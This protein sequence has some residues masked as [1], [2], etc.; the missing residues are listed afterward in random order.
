[1]S[2]SLGHV[3]I[4]I[5]LVNPVLDLLKGLKVSLLFTEEQFTVYIIN[6]AHQNFFGAT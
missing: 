6:A 2:D 3:D 1:M 5:G 4:A